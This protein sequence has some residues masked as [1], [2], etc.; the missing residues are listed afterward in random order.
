MRKKQIIAFL[1]FCA[2]LLMG[3]QV[4]EG[5]YA[6][7]ASAETVNPIYTSNTSTETVNSVSATNAST[8]IVNSVY[9]EEAVKDMDKVAENEF[10]ELYLD[11]EETVVAIRQKASGALWF[12]NPV[13][14]ELDTFSN[15]YYK[16]VLKSQIDVTYIDENTKISTMNNYTSSIENGQ[17]EIE[18]IENGV[19]ITY[20]IGDSA[21]LIRLP[22]AITE[23]RM[24]MFYNQMSESQQ[25][26]IDRNYNLYD[27]DAMDEDQK[28]ELLAKYPVLEQQNLY[29]LRSGTKDYMKEE[30]A[31]YFEEVGYTQE[32]FE[33]DSSNAS[34][35]EEDGKAWFR[36]PLVYQLDGENLVVTINPEEIEYNTSGYYLVNLDILRYFGASLNEDG[37]LFVPDGS[38]ALINFNNGKT[39]EASYG[40]TV[41][42][43]DATMIYTTWYQSQVDADKTIKMPVFGIKDGNKAVFTIV[44]EG[45]AY[46]AIKADIS[47][48]FTGYNDAYASF[49]YLQYGSTSLSDMV[50]AA[51]YYMYSDA[52]FEG[53][54]KLRY[55]FL[56]GENASYSGM[57]SCYREYLV[58]QGVLRETAEDSA[59]PF[60][61]EY[62]G[63]IDRPKTFLGIKYDAVVPVTTFAQAKEITELLKNSG[64]SNLNVIYSGWTDGG[65]HGKAVTRLKAESKLKNGGVSLAEFQDITKELAVDLYMTLDL[66]YVYRD[67]LTDGYSN[68]RYAP[69]YFDNTVIKI[70][71][72]GLA[73]RVSEDTLA[74][75][76]S[77]YYVNQIT[78][79]L[80]NRLQKENITGVNIG[81]L[82]R[83]LYSDLQSKVYTD[84]QMAITK[85]TLAMQT[86]LEANQNLISDNANV[87]A[88]KYSK[89]V[90]NA[91]LYSNRYRVI[92]EEIPFY[93]MVLHG[94]I[95][96]SGEAMNLSDDYTTTLLK[97]AESG[98]GLYF[99]WIYEE[100]SVLKDTEYDY[101][102]SVNYKAWLEKAVTDY[103]RMNEE[104]GHLSGCEII[105]HEYVC[106]DVAKVT[107][108]DGSIVYVNFT[109]SSVNVDGVLVPARDYTVIKEAS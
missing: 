7:D 47:G 36:I 107:Y 22:E 40:A 60:Y 75:L 89:D 39:N 32:D 13:D 55:C 11:E 96:Y 93:E 23:E 85:N 65:L 83:E 73:S 24:L 95:S 56:N 37:Y 67:T 58:N 51:S 92:D 4:P 103:R 31:I 5:V 59:L 8:K 62:I 66:Q 81:T 19:K 88:L 102:Y 87:Y 2:C 57:A 108:E 34:G 68:I 46:A 52:V 15:N 49:T 91:P 105:S 28:K 98:A 10:L 18:E 94:H 71:K 21:L 35:V 9:A 82:S 3:V 41:Y 100:N 64:I 53:N 80:C 42:G 38:G 99:R 26:K 33:L 12:S 70:N 16:K 44:E 54:Y 17:F 45:D 69:R 76:I 1:L 104:M 86:L 43:Q 74:N 14:E 101:L 48:K 72:Y 109:E 27:V 90:I 30:L 78:K 6:S 61:V 106:E 25:K 84:R 97:T 29:V 77:P 63:A 20:F 79:N 50:G